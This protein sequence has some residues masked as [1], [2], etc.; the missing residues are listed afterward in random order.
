MVSSHLCHILLVTGSAHTREG[1]MQGKVGGV[2]GG[3][4]KVCP[5]VILTL[6]RI[7]R[8]MGWKRVKHEISSLKDQLLPITLSGLLQETRKAVSK[9]FRYLTP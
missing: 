4:L 2:P 7:I 8:T 3:H 6:I 5:P 1:I 9:S